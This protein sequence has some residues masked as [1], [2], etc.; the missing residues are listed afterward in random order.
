VKTQRRGSAGEQLAAAYLELEGFSVEARN[1]RIAGVEVDLVAR[2]GGAR[3]L[4]EVKFRSRID[5]GGAALAV[6]RGKRERLL[7]AARAVA[8]REPMPV[9]IDVIAIEPCDGGARILHYRS[10]VAEEP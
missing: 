2:D 9:R 8:S 6:D 5:Y 4:V 3:V 10:A 7:R 1:V